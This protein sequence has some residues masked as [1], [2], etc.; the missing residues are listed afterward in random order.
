MSMDIVHIYTCISW[1]LQSID[2][3]KENLLKMY[4]GF[5]LKG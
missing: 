5:K 4:A 1:F 2:A 3:F